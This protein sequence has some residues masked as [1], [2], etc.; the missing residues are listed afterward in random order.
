MNR[1]KVELGSPGEPDIVITIPPGKTVQQELD[2][3]LVGASDPGSIEVIDL[4]S[5]GRITMGTITLDRF[6]VDVRGSDES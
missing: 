4:P 3:F 2:E 1:L 5:G 6:V